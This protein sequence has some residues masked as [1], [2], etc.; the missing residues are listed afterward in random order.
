[1]NSPRLQ[2]AARAGRRLVA[3]AFDDRRREPVTVTEVVM[4]VVERRGRIEVER[5]E[6]LH[7]LASRDELSMLRLAARA[8]RTIAGEEDGDGVEV[9]AG[10]ASHPMVGVIRT[11]VAE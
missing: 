7:P 10:Q 8:L 11:R 3:R 4:R 6:H 2:R 9:R 5:R 1:M